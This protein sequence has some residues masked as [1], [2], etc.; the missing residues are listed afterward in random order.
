M[1]R[2][3]QI[4][5]LLV[6]GAAARQSIALSFNITFVDDA[7]GTFASRGWLDPNSLFQQNIRAAANLWGARINSNQTIIVRVDTHSF[8][9][10]AGGTNSS[11]RLLYTHNGKN[12]WEPGPLSRVL[13]GSNAGATFYGYDILLG[14][15]ANFVENNY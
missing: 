6:L 14:F 9:A 8:A 10:R 11:G 1:R 4:L 2:A 5:V 7:S 13:T 15:D 12:V 3:F